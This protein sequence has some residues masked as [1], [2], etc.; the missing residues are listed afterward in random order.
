[1]SN[2]T[3]LLAF[4]RHPLLLLSTLLVLSGTAFAQSGDPERSGRVEQLRVYGSSLDGNLEGN[5]PERLFETFYTTKPQ[6]LGVGL[7]I[8]RSIIESHGGRLWAVENRNGGLSFYFTLPGQTVD[9]S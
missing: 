7:S 9:E 6:G 3:R 1:M 8:S 4:L 5:D 2:R